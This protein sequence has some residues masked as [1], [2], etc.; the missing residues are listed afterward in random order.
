MPSAQVI[1][2][3][4]S[5]R[6][7]TAK[8]CRELVLEIDAELRKSPGEGGTPVQTGHARANWVPSIGAPFVGEVSGAATHDAAVVSL[9]RYVLEQGSLWVS[10]NV[11]YIN[12]LN[13]GHSKQ[14]PSGFVEAAID[15]ALATV[16]G[17]HDRLKLDLKTT[18]AGT[19]SDFAGGSAAGNVA[20]AY[21][22]FGGGDD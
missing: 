11:P 4:K 7:E 10:N 14:A 2:L 21:S 17:R 22:P 15:R 9:M 16:Q 18:G 19:F 3:E 12:M 8:A 1:A 5:L 20:S 13:L 6:A